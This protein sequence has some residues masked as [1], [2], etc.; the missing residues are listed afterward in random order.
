MV[1]SFAP[2]PAERH[3]PNPSASLIVGLIAGLAVLTL[4][5]AGITFAALAVAFPIAVP[6]AEAWHLP[7]AA[8]DRILAGQFAALWWA[9]AALA[10]ASFSAALVIVVKLIGFLSPGPRD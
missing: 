4:I 2:Q 3:G 9:F 8:A 10:V 6:V 1:T 7:V 5:V